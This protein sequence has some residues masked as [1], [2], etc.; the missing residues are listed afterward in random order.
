MYKLLVSLLAIIVFGTTGF[1]QELKV[2]PSTINLNIG[3]SQKLTAQVV[4]KKGKVVDGR[5]FAFYSTK[6]RAMSADSTG[7][8]TAH[9]AGEYDVIVISPGKSVV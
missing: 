1:S 4:D 2:S 5:T 9:L 8:I 6:R 7:L 3:K